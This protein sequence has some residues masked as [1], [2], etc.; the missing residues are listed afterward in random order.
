MVLT[1]LAID[2]RETVNGTFV[3]DGPNE[4]LE[5]AWI[6]PTR[7]SRYSIPSLISTRFKSFPLATFSPSTSER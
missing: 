6:F 4:G 2:I 3:A 1:A 5:G 7:T